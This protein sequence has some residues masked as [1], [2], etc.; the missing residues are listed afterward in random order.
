MTPTICLEDGACIFD[1]QYQ[2]R[3]HAVLYCQPCQTWFHRDCL[4]VVGD[5][6]TVRRRQIIRF[7]EHLEFCFLRA[8]APDFA[9][10]P[11][12]PCH[13]D[14][15]ASTRRSSSCRIKH[16]VLDREAVTRRSLVIRTARAFTRGTLGIA[17]RSIVHV[18]HQIST[19]THARVPFVTSTPTFQMPPKKPASAKLPRTLGKP[20][21]HAAPPASRNNLSLSL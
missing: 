3:V 10:S 20:L 16:R 1:R 15:G 4:D 12:P 19:V 21:R 9:S 11:S 8:P 6:E 17:A 13:T 2:P 18:F 7:S 14:A 5:L